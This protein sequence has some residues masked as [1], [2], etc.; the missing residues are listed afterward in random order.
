MEERY[1]KKLIIN[2]NDCFALYTFRLELLKKLRKKYTLYIIA[3]RDEYYSLLLDEGFDVIDSFV[4]G[5]K[6]NI[7]KD[8]SLLIFYKK[9]FKKIKPDIIINYTI[10]PHIYGTLSSKNSKIINFISGVGSVFL[11]QNIIYRLSVLMYKLVAKKV[12]LYIFLNND[13][14]NEFKR[15]KLIKNRYEIIKGEGVNLNKFYHEVN[16]NL[17]PTFIFIGRLVEEKGILE[18]LE[19]AKTIKQKNP[20]V[21]FLVVGSFYD[22]QSVVDKNLIYSLHEEGIIEYLGY[23][24]QINEVLRSVH[25]VV[26]PS[27]REGLPI[28]LV[29]GLASK[30]FLIASNVPGCRDVCIDNYNGFL[31]EPKSVDGLV[32]AIEKYLNYEDKFL[33]HE[34]A[35]NSSFEYDKEFYIQKMVDFI[36]EL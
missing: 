5:S 6:K 7:F 1:R 15:N 24:Y 31:V 19:A 33:L 35:L 13:D 28:S 23:S 12:N 16:F 22:K 10:K 11:I 32:M 21:R 29:E 34:N 9:I 27:Y 30:K 18:Y 2:C 20:K 25:V 17:P 14:L 36:E 8:I 4:E 26:L 3:R